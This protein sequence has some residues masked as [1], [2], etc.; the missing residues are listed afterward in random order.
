MSID[1]NSNKLIND[2]KIFELGS[3]Y[4]DKS[5][6]TLNNKFYFHSN[7]LQ[8]LNK[9][10]IGTDEPIY[11]YDI[12]KGN[13]RIIPDIRIEENDTAIRVGT[14]N[15]DTS[16]LKINENIDES[17]SVKDGYT[18]LYNKN[19]IYKDHF[20]VDSLSNYTIGSGGSAVFNT[21]TKDEITIT[22]ADNITNTITYNFNKNII[23]GSLKIR[24]K[25]IADFP[26][27]NNSYIMLYNSSTGTGSN[28]YRLNFS[29]S[30]YTSNLLKNYSGTNYQLNI[31]YDYDDQ[32]SYHN[33][34]IEFTPSHIR[35]LLNDVEMNT[36]YTKD[37]NEIEVDSFLLWNNQINCYLKFI[38]LYELV[39]QSYFDL[40]YMGSRLNNNKSLSIFVDNELNLSDEKVTISQDG[41][42]GIGTTMPESKLHLESNTTGDVAILTVENA[43]YQ[44][45]SSD[46][47]SAIEIRSVDNNIAALNLR[48][49]NNLKY[50]IG[51]NPN[52]GIIKGTGYVSSQISATR[53]A[54]LL[55]NNKISGSENAYYWVTAGGSTVVGSWVGYEF[56]RPQIVNRYYLWPRN[57]NAKGQS[58]SAWQLRAASSKSVYDSGT[59]TILQT[60]SGLTSSSWTSISNSHEIVASENT[61]LG[62]YYS[63]TNTNEYRYYVIYFTANNVDNTNT[64]VSLSEIQFLFYNDNTNKEGAFFMK[65]V[66]ED[67]NRLVIDTLDNVGIGTDYPITG[68]H[69]TNCLKVSSLVYAE[70]RTVDQ[71]N[72]GDAYGTYRAPI[73]VFTSG[74]T[75]SMSNLV[76]LTYTSISGRNGGGGR[77]VS[78]T[79]QVPGIYCCCINF[80]LD[81][82]NANDWLSLGFEKN[83]ISAT[84]GSLTYNVG[85]WISRPY[86]HT[87]SDRT[88]T[89][90]SVFIECN[91]TTDYIVPYT[92]SLYKGE[93]ADVGGESYITIFKIN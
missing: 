3:I 44:L 39:P 35:F 31:A 36:F 81:V 32:T 2:N 86:N 45:G 33:F 53:G 50:Q 82:T 15:R 14:N 65:D 78:F 47:D 75:R 63:F 88:Y 48:Y 20:T 21:S 62:N 41:K 67:K 43:A 37:T 23:A 25:K 11:D 6:I 4:D 24:M 58:P 56:T 66:N 80:F 89:R 70:V 83:F 91:G 55:F 61:N 73:P 16:I 8:F 22:T 85:Q 71:T 27:D 30:A 13:I 28:Y 64:Y 54:E 7:S 51:F 26:N 34:E 90:G 10:G 17:D 59:Y 68:L 49:N 79:P 42:I 72:F 19:L 76:T 93:V 38:E 57:S 69:I 46:Y 5:A 12:H 92:Q 74:N 29:G 77:T 84:S 87:D 1:I 52:L 40:R 9:V 60:I 18:S